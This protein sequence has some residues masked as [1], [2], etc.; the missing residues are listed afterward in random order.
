MSR[1]EKH[2]PEF[3]YRCTWCMHD[4]DTPVCPQCGPELVFRK[5][6][7]HSCQWSRHTINTVQCKLCGRVI[8]WEEYEGL[9]AAPAGGGIQLGEI[10]DG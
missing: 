2:N 1:R 5:D 4:V 7:P 3:Q 8:T 10:K 9:A 6:A